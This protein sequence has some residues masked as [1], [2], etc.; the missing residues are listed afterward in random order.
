MRSASVCVCVVGSVVRRRESAGTAMRDGRVVG[1]GCCRGVAG[2][3]GSLELL[4]K[5]VESLK[6]ALD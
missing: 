2:V 3:V 4:E 5:S 6:V 1:P